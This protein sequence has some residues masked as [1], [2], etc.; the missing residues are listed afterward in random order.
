[1][2]ILNLGCGSKTSA[3]SDVIN[4]DWSIGLRIR[5][6]RL[7]R[8]FAPLV[9]RG[10][11]RA[12]FDSLPPNI[13]VHDLSKGIPRDA[14]SVRAV[15]LSHVLEHID[16]SEVPKILGE[17]LRVLRPGGII[18]I[19][20]PDLERICRSYV[21]FMDKSLP[22]SANDLVYEKILSELLEQ[23]VRKEAAGT[24]QQPFVRRMIENLAL[25][26]AR[27]RGET[28]Q[29]MYDRYSLPHTLLQSGFVDPEVVSWSA[30]SIER[31]SE[32]GLDVGPGGGEYKPGSLYVEARA[33]DSV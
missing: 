18:R 26:D 14:A 4:I 28:H 29:W 33:P 32:Y 15:Y 7:L 13:L 27:K 2:T 1:M 25:G 17:A 19:V 20:V 31:W 6:N 3:S 23:S 8:P 5:T 9:F 12:R 21:A 24:S 22:S 30:S 16:R 11:R 10:D